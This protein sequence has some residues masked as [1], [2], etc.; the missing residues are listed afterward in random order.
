MVEVVLIAVGVVTAFISC[1]DSLWQNIK[2]LLPVVTG[3]TVHGSFE[4]SVPVLFPY[5]EETTVHNPYVPLLVAT[6]PKGR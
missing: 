4:V 2:R 5:L 1:F 6:P 3:Q